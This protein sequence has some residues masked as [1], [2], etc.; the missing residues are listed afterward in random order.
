SRAEE[1]TGPATEP[2]VDIEARA[3][4]WRLDVVCTR[5]VKPEREIFNRAVRAGRRAAQR[6]PH[7]R[8]AREAKATRPT[9]RVKDQPPFVS[10]RPGL[11]L[12]G[13]IATVPDRLA[14]N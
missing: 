3:S 9:L 14:A 8:R 1:R 11:T 10:R 6:V 5:V 7:A 12:F 2:P 13:A 4:S